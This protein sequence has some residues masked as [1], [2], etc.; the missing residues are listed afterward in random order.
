[1][2]EDI[3]AVLRMGPDEQVAFERNQNVYSIIKAME[4]LEHKYA[5]GGIKGPDYHKIWTD[6]YH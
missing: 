5:T 1:M 4:F 6:L 2:V 3:H